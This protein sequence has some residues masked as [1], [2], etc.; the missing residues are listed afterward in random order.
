M[1]ETEAKITKYR[2]NCHCGGFVFEIEMP[3]VK[4]IV[5]CNC[6]ICIKKS[7]V[8]L[9]PGV[10]LNIIKDEGLH[11]EYSFG[12]KNLTHRFCSKC[13]TATYGT[14]AAYP[15]PMN[16]G[17]N[18]RCIQNLDVWKLNT[19]FYDGA[20]GDPKYTPPA[21][22][23]PEPTPAGIPE[24]EGKIYHGSCHCGAVTVAVK[25]KHPIDSEAYTEPVMEC[26]CSAC[27]RGGETRIYP[28]KDALI[29]QGKENITG[30][31]FGH[32]VWRDNFCKIC[33]VHIYKDLNEEQT[34]ED[35]ANLPEDIQKF[36]NNFINHR[37]FNLRVLNDLDVDSP[38]V[39]GKVRQVDGWTRQSPPYVN[40]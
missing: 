3:E 5:L 10:E 19:K 27:M 8:S 21:Y 37:P 40:P 16:L 33:G 7:Y 1:A 36:R 24:N 38:G 35:I 2:G 14:A 22:T 15:P 25:T 23:G 18:A 13:G 34:E 30:Y 32:K 31:V 11:T 12:N 4:Q 17:V 26:N 20:T 6:S 28:L 9:M 29:V 39:K